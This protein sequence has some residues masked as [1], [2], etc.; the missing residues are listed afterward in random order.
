MLSCESTETSDF[1]YFFLDMEKKNEHPHRISYIYLGAI[2][3]M[4]CVY[5]LF[6]IIMDWIK[7]IY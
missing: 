6:H 4:D 2:L 5:I 7:I 1:F 3:N